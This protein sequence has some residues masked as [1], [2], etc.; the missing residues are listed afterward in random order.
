MHFGPISKSAVRFLISGVVLC[1]LFISACKQN[2]SA[3]SVVF[4]SPEA[5]A[6]VKAGDNVTADLQFTPEQEVDSIVYYIDSAVVAHR[7]DTASLT[8]STKGIALG[9]HLISAKIYKKDKV[10]EAATNIVVVSSKTPEQYTYQVVNTFP[11]DTSSYTQGLEYHDGIFYESAGGV[12]DDGIGISSLRKVQ[13]ETGKVLKKIDMPETI[14][15]E[16]ITVVGNRIVQLTWQNGYG[17]F[18]NKNT[19]EKLSEFPYQSSREGW[20]LCFD[21]KQIYKSDGSNRIYIL[22]KDSCKEIGNIEVFDNK[23]EV[24]QL[25]ELEYIDGKIY[26]NVYQTDKIVIINPQTGEVEAEINL[27]GLLPAADHFP[28]TDVLNGIA[29]DAAKQRLFVTGKKWSKL[30]EIK[31]VKK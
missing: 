10:E 13:P 3:V 7:T 4:I 15:A 1:L 28:N 22:D 31:L 30:F 24:T 17:I 19:L 8:L 14:F 27:T 21:G 29:W 18:Y 9:N 11:H 5:G 16:G 26:A 2:R 23:G 6:S 12:P 20:G 25:N